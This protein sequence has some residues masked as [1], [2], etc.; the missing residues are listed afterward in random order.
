MASILRAVV[1]FSKVN[2]V[3]T[4][5]SDPVN[6]IVMI[7]TNNF[8]GGLTDVTAETKAVLERGSAGGKSLGFRN[9]RCL[10]L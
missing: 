6:F 1:F 3:Y 4:G 2:K 8:R 9:Y 10:Q 7:K 5:S